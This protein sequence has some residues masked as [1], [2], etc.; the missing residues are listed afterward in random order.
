MGKTFLVYPNQTG[1][2]CV[3]SVSRCQILT[4]YTTVYPCVS[5]T[6]WDTLCIQCVY[7][8]C[9]VF[10]PSRLTTATS[11]PRWEIRWIGSLDT[12]VRIR[13]KS[14]Y[15]ARYMSMYRSASDYRYAQIRTYLTEVQIR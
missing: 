2:H 4:T 1:I 5:K 7:V 9:T 15:V 12:C 10:F 13:P 14:T 6:K 3:S 8:L 11:N